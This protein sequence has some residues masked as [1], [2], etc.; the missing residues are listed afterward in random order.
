MSAAECLDTQLAAA[1]LSHLA[2]LCVSMARRLWG[3]TVP[4]GLGSQSKCSQRPSGKASMTY[5]GHS[6]MALDP[7]LLVRPVSEVG[8]DPLAGELYP[9]FSRRSRHSILGCLYPR[10]FIGCC[11]ILMLNS[12]SD[13]M[14][15]KI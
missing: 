14:S 3:T 4:T 6:R 11:H 2:S 13:L 1:G 15:V 10:N 12:Q 5:L 7:I 9:H 8:P